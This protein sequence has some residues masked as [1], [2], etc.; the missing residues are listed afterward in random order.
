MMKQLMKLSRQKKNMFLIKTT[1]C[2]FNK[3][4]VCCF[5]LFIVLLLFVPNS[6]AQEFK[7]GLKGGICASQVS[8][9][10]LSGFDKAGLILGGY[11]ARS[12]S[13]RVALQ[14]EIMYIQKG[15]RKNA[16]PDKG[17]YQSYIM[18]LNYIEI[19]V[20]LNW[21]HKKKWG[22][23]IG[24][25]IG[26]LF[27]SYEADEFGVFVNARPF[28]PTEIAINFGLNY[29]MTENLFVNTRYGNSVLPIRDHVSGATYK[30]NWGQYNTAISF[31]LNYQF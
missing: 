2:Q 28:N 14:M 30:L 8:G 9:D 3:G 10:D 13:E 17:D 4:F 16:R 21:R 22:F 27:K 19:P 25:S 26:Y 1:P 11:V 29:Y 12:L 31:T 18:R 7:G 5:S 24:P 23:E 20:L 15:S 6:Y